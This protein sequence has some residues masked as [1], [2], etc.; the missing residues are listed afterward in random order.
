MKSSR[1]SRGPLE[2]I[3]EGGYRPINGQAG[4][5]ITRSKRINKQITP[6]LNHLNTQLGI[7]RRM[8]SR[9]RRR[10]A[11]AQCPY[12]DQKKRGDGGLSAHITVKHPTEIDVVEKEMPFVITP[13]SDIFRARKANLPSSTCPVCRAAV[14]DIALHVAERHGYKRFA[15]PRCNQTVLTTP[16]E[17]TL[18]SGCNGRFVTRHDRAVA[19]PSHVSKREWARTPA[20][21]SQTRP[22]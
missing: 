14:I 18:C 17:S 2:Q 21:R 3:L 10:A 12:C 8:K 22:R 20:S 15:C 16:D 1:S 5:G 19:V 9:R 11:L 4:R 6:Y 7:V 13:G